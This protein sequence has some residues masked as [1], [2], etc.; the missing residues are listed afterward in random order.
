MLSDNKVLLY[1][2]KN[3]M[4][5]IL[6][7]ILLL[8]VCAIGA[9]AQR[10]GSSKKEAAQSNVW[11]IG[12][13]GGARVNFMKIT[14]LSAELD[15]DPV[16]RCGCVFSA[17]VCRDFLDGFLSVRPQ[18]SYASRGGMYFCSESKGWTISKDY[19]VRIRYI[20]FRMPLILNLVGSSSRSR[21]VPYVY[22]SPI[23]G[24]TVGGKISLDGSVLF[25]AV[26]HD[27]L[28]V[29][30]ANVAQHYFAVGAGA[31]AKYKFEINRK[32]FFLGF[33][34]LYDFGF[35][36]TYGKNERDGKSI[37]VGHLVDYEN[38]PLKGK[39]SFSGVEMQ[40]Y[41]G[42]PFGTIH[43]KKVKPQTTRSVRN[44]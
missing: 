30:K 25:G 38:A 40:V 1:N 4:K 20:D 42:V 44:L 29:S 35:T 12:V 24:E 15:A 43:P 37:D 11:S 19:E 22:V 13:G 27:K 5:R 33:E 21:I 28:R 34:A 2:K 36:N 8:S 14:R 16:S 9:S 26:R 10:G 7:T 23:F 17:F 39:R 6:L 3:S 18:V 31:G 32:E 41:F